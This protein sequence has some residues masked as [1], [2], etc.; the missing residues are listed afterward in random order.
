MIVVMQSD[1]ELNVLF[2][3]ICALVYFIFLFSVFQ[4]T[5]PEVLEGLL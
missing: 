2:A 3:T 1:L 5:N 4:F